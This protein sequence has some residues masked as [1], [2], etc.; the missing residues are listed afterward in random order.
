MLLGLQGCCLG[1][2]IL[3]VENWCR[4]AVR[5]DAGGSDKGGGAAQAALHLLALA[6]KWG[7][8]R[9][10]RGLHAGQLTGSRPRGSARHEAVATDAVGRAALRG[11]GAVP[12]GKLGP[13]RRC[14][15]EG[16]RG[17]PLRRKI[18]RGRNRGGRRGPFPQAR[19][20]CGE[21]AGADRPDDRPGDRRELA[22]RPHRPD[23]PCA[24]PRRRRGDGRGR[25]PRRRSS[26]P[27]TSILRRPSS[28][29]GASRG[30]STQCSTIWRA[31]RSRTI[32]PRPARCRPR[33]GGGRKRCGSH[34]CG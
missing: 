17:S 26:S 22:D 12:D 10:R 28:R 31:R 7:K 34:S 27:N 23:A 5:A 11:A 3:T 14:R 4:P 25:A 16:V 18:R 8:P 15:Q 21:L 6:R 13:V 1:N 24:V 32:S 19:R 2:G 29:T 20:R 33:P 9:P 30:L